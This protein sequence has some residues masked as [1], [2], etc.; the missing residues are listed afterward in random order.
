MNEICSWYVVVQK[1]ETRL[2]C[3]LREICIEFRF[4]F[5]TARNETSLRDTT[6]CAWWTQDMIISDLGGT[7][8]HYILHVISFLKFENGFSMM[9]ECNG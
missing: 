4:Q 7:G 6:P 8:L 3:W 2:V 1:C 9:A 5:K